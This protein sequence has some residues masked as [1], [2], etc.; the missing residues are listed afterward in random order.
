MSPFSLP[1]LDLAGVE[2]G[3]DEEGLIPSIRPIMTLHPG[4]EQLET[5]FSE[6]RKAN[7]LCHIRSN[8][9]YGP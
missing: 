9:R 6:I 1:Y 4:L 7:T 8:C 3:Y 5:L 2:V